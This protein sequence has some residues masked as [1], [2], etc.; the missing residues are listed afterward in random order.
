MAFVPEAAL[1]ALRE[2]LEA[3]LITGILLGLVTKLGRA[4]ARRWV[5]GGFVA[6]AV[7]SLAVGLAVQRFLLDAFEAQGGA[8]VFELV[9]ALAAV[10]VLTYMIVWM[11]KHTRELM[12]TVRAQVADALA[13]GDVIAI[14]FLT[15]ASVLREGLE[16]VLFYGAL[17]S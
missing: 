2:G 15:F 3:L 4:D 11:W 14:A 8:E 7:A 16:T 10:G 1:I 5:W 9:A 13:R 12:T 6:G 17:A